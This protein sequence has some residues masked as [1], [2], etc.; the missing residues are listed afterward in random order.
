MIKPTGGG[1][2]DGSGPLLNPKAGYDKDI[3]LTTNPLVTIDLPGAGGIA[4]KCAPNPCLA[5]C[6]C[7]RGI[8]TGTGDPRDNDIQNNCCDCCPNGGA[9]CAEFGGQSG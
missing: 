8:C 2:P 5:C 7:S 3:V 6:A 9:V 1:C 4:L